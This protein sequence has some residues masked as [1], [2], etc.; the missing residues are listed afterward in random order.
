MLGR[1]INLDP[2]AIKMGF[3]SDR[4]VCIRLEQSALSIWPPT[5]WFSLEGFDLAA[6]AVAGFLDQPDVQLAYREHMPHKPRAWWVHSPRAC[7]RRKQSLSGRIEVIH[8]TI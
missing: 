7:S 5:R 1:K 8:P 6:A 3:A 4:D 2:P